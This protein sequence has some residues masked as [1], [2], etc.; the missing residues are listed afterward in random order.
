MCNLEDRAR[1][2]DK[3]TDCGF[4]RFRDIE[5]SARRMVLFRASMAYR[6][7]LGGVTYSRDS[8][9]ATAWLRLGKG[10]SK[11]AALLNKWWNIVEW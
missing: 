7:C 1:L 6:G 2:T 3:G 10:L 9:D 4:H 5:C 8:G 11:L